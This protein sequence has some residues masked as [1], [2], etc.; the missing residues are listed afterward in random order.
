MQNCGFTEKEKMEF[1]S[2]RKKWVKKHNFFILLQLIISFPYLFVGDHIVARD[3]DG[4]LYRGVVKRKQRDS[5]DYWV[6]FFYRAPNNKTAINV[7]DIYRNDIGDGIS[8][9]RSKRI[10]YNQ[11]NPPY[12]E[13]AYYVYGP[14]RICW[15]YFANLQEHEHL[16]HD[17]NFYDYNDVD[18]EN[19]ADLANFFRD[20]FDRFSP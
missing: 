3:Y 16:E 2:G 8:K 18:Y 19:Y 15:K 6:F 12:D 1:K 7:S 14:C 17:S 5:N 20:R 10:V 9:S 13:D 4:E 11:M